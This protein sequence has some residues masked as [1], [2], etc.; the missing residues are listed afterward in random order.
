[1]AD[2]SYRINRL[3]NITKGKRYLEIGVQKGV[4]FTRVC[5]DRL[6][7]VDPNFCFDIHSDARK[8]VN[9]F[10]V[11]SDEYFK[12]PARNLQFDVIFIDGLHTFEQSKRDILNAINVLAPGGIIILDDVYP[13][14]VFSAIP[15]SS[16]DAIRFRKEVTPNTSDGRWH[17]DVF[18]TLFF[19]HENLFSLDF[20]TTP[21][22]E[23]NCQAIIWRSFN[24][25][26]REPLLKKDPSQCDFFDTRFRPELYRFLP[27][28]EI[29]E[30]LAAHQS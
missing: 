3:L 29:Y 20:H 28:E 16:T 30:L 17:G 6:D 14:D 8:G 9:F 5:A 11:G 26:Y 13:S 1:M 25:C 22:A 2:S 10:A 23:G 12:Q 18:K 24:T 27:F 15:T 19:I 4:T 21:P 7:A